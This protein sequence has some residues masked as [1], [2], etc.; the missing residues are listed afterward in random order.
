MKVVAFNNPA[1]S[2]TAQ[3][4]V[5]VPLSRCISF[6]H[7]MFNER[8]H[9]EH[10]LDAIHPFGEASLGLLNRFCSPRQTIP[11]RLFI[12][13]MNRIAEEVIYPDYGET[14]LAYQYPHERLRA[15]KHT[16]RSVIV[17]NQLSIDIERPKDI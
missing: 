16:L 3:Y 13:Q 4:F 11:S 5:F 12:V 2:P 17:L 7:V 14:C 8:Y 6:R 10:F 1:Y 9:T 15:Y